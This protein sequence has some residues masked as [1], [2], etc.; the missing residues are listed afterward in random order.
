MFI[1]HTTV[2]QLKSAMKFKTCLQHLKKLSW[3]QN[4][5]HLKIS[6]FSKKYN[7]INSSK[8]CKIDQ[9]KLKSINPTDKIQAREILYDS[10]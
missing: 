2:P 7:K 1:F 10:F 5:E 4:L 6:G 9:R 3:P 8:F